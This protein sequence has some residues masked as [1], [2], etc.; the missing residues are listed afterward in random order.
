V[1]RCGL[2]VSS[3]LSTCFRRQRTKIEDGW[4]GERGNAIASPNHGI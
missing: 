3:S 2:L 1:P 4:F